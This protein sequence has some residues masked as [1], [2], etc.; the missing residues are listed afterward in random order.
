M[1]DS[2]STRQK[3][4]DEEYE[5]LAGMSKIVIQEVEL[6]VMLPLFRTY[7]LH[8]LGL[9]PTVGVLL[10]GP[11]GVGKT[12]LAHA[13]AKK[14]NVPIYKISVT[15]CLSG[16]L[17]GPE[18]TIKKIFLE[19]N[20][21]APAIVFIDDIDAVTSNNGDFHDDTARLRIFSQLRKCIDESYQLSCQKVSERSD[22]KCGCVVI[23]AETTRLDAIHPSLKTGERFGCQIAVDY[24]NE[25]ARNDIL[26][27]FASKDKVDAGDIRKVARSTAGFV[28]ADLASLVDKAR[29]LAVDDRKDLTLSEFEKAGKMVQ[30]LIREG[31]SVLPCLNWDD[32]GGLGY[33]KRELSIEIVDR[34][35]RP[36][37]F[38]EHGLDLWAG[39]LLYGPPGIGKALVA[40]AAANEAGATFIH[41]KGLELPKNYY[42]GSGLAEIFRRAR[43][44]SPCVIFFEEVHTL[45]SKDRGKERGL[46]AK[47][48][49]YT[50]LQ[51]FDEGKNQGLFLIGSTDRLEAMD[52]S[53]LRYG[54]FGKR[55][56]IPLPSP[57]DRGKIMAVLA[58]KNNIHTDAD[59]V[60]LGMHSLVNFSG[61]DI[62]K[63]LNQ[64]FVAASKRGSA[65]S[66]IVN[67]EDFVTALK[68]ISP[69][70][71]KEE[72]Q[73]YESVA[74][75]FKLL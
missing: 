20:S 75:E 9:T 3:M 60:G 31:F 24:P 65:D 73:H 40:K 58:R 19:A 41:I 54:R 46:V 16:A 72:N 15:E 28:G 52:P 47:Q 21:T 32:V 11:P 55:Y 45:L 44:C 68:K 37:V 6:A 23:I 36:E 33:L 56:Y 42:G 51:E 13:V 70:I 25:E 38:E 62:S 22:E 4:E 64:A 57:G 14:A 59:L 49:Y 50:L 2:D 1:N 39:I 53:V 5:D 74:K 66:R 29:T 61:A 8:H 12:M 43:I 34:S 18:E 63:L 26:V 71:S 48:L 69:T 10:H 17:V 67:N 30:P 35:K 7:L 27:K